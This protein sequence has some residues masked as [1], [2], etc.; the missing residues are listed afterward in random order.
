M[1]SD[2]VEP[3]GQRGFAGETFGRPGEF[4]E[5]GLC[6]VPC[7][8]GITGHAIARSPHELDVSVDQ[9]GECS[10]VAVFRIGSEQLCVVT[11]APLR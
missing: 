8:I 7:Q 1:V 2:A 3:S 11:H 10:L 4:G 6:D 5:D 9:L